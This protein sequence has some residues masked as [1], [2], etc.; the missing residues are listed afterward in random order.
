MS[1]CCIAITTYI[2]TY[3]TLQRLDMSPSIIYFYVF[4]IA[5]F[6]SK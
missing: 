3:K 6:T 2:H 4:K 5:K 1:T